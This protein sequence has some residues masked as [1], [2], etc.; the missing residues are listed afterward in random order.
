[1]AAAVAPQVRCRRITSSWIPTVTGAWLWRG[2]HHPVQNERTPAG[3][4][5]DT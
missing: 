3:G 2:T 5:G 1:M 4:E